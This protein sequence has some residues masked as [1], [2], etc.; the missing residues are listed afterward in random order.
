M[1]RSA[2]SRSDA[3]TSSSPR[4]KPGMTRTFQINTLSP[5]MTGLESVV[6]AI[7][8][9]RGRVSNEDAAGS[10]GGGARLCILLFESNNTS[11]GGP[12]SGE[13]ECNMFSDNACHHP[14]MGLFVPQEAQYWRS[15]CTSLSIR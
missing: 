13:G 5:G 8:E 4:A 12:D 7:S 10:V 9:R 15:T 11:L 2:F 14:G 1:I 6:P 3:T